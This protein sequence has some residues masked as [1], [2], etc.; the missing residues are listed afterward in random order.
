MRLST[1]WRIFIG[2]LLVLLS[3][4]WARGF[5]FDAGLR[6]QYI[7]ALAFL[8]AYFIMPACIWI[9]SR[10]GILD[11]PDWRKIHERP[12]PLLGGLGI[13]A[14]FCSALL[15]NGVFLQGM[16]ALLAGATMILVMGLLDDV[17]PIPAPLKFVVQILITLYVVIWGD[18]HL[19]FF[20]NRT[21]APFF[22]LPVTVIWIVGLTNALNFFDGVDG[23]AA[24]I[25]TVCGLFL[26]LIAFKTH[27]PAL[28]WFAVAL[29]GS[30]LGFFPYNFRI[31]E[32]ALLFLGD[33]GSTF[34]GFTLAG[35]AVMGR[36]S[37]TSHFVS[38]SAPILIFGVLIFDMIYVNLSRIRNGQ[39]KG[40][41]ELLSCV[42]KDHL[43]HRLIFMGFAKKETV[44]IIS[45]L[46]VCLGVSA[47]IIMDQQFIQAVLGLFQA[48]I[49]IGLIVALMLKGRD[50]TPPGGDRRALKRRHEDRLDLPAS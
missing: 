45:T 15:M 28:G 35:L 36:W 13:Y 46:S 17:R 20:Y 42:N 37:N 23:L 3:T 1:V 12:T 2:L 50:R 22:N 7:F 14:A 24:S 33:A 39:A 43:H 5:Y 10:L 44:F 41:L 31:G 25:S 9:A 11:R 34:L 6:W 29:V 18:I 19:T 21:W 38:L 8:T 4:P 40:L 16:K 48:V 49:I 27:Q 32:S 47:L 30:C 26:G